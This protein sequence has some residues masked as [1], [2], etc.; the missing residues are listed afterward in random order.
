MNASF[1]EMN[2]RHTITINE[3]T[4]KKLIQTG[5]FGETYSKLISRLVDSMG[6][7]SEPKSK[8]SKK[9]AFLATDKLN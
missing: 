2:Y 8:E 5:N 7:S 4:Y 3:E 1:N 9:D 6:T